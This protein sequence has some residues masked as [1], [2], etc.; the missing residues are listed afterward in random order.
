MMMKMRNQTKWNLLFLLQAVCLV[1]VSHGYVSQRIPSS[2][3]VRG[4]RD[5]ELI[6]K[7]TTTRVR[8]AKPSEPSS[9][10]S[11]AMA[12]ATPTRPSSSGRSSFLRSSWYEE[13]GHPVA[14]RRPSFA[15]D[16]IEWELDGNEY[17]TTRRT[18]P[19]QGVPSYSYTNTAVG[20]PPRRRKRRQLKRAAKWVFQGLFQRD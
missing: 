4:S 1:M 7:T 3:F 14:R 20:R 6:Q 10:T 17:D 5:S 13:C 11:F 18:A 19:F 9:T 8:K 12:I 16:D 15:D 2:S